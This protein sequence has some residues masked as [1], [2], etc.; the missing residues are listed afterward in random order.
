MTG[1]VTMLVSLRGSQFELRTGVW[2][3]LGRE[4]VGERSRL[5]GGGHSGAGDSGVRKGCL[6]SI[7]EQGIYER[8]E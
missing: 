8:Q 4:V 3:L 5:F 2:R 7:H 6:V 1:V